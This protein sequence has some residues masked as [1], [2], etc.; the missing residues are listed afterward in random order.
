MRRSVCLLTNAYPDFPDSSRVVFIRQLAGLLSERDM[1]V[2][3]VAPR[4]F[5]GSKPRER[6]GAIEVR[7]FASFLE[8]K[9]LVQYER[10]PVF[11]L[12]GYM[13]AGALAAI[14]CVRERKCDLIHA[15]WVIPAGLIALVA[16]RICRKPVVVTAHGSD[17]L[18]VPGRSG[19]IGKLVKYVLGHADAVTSVADHL[20]GLIAEMGI[21][22]EKVLT[23][24]MSV[25][26]ESFAPEGDAQVGWEG[27]AVIFSNRSLYPLYNVETL[28][29]ATPAI[30]EKTPNAQV[31]IAGEGPER[32][33]LASLASELGVSDRVEFIGMI[34]HERMPEYLRGASVYVSTALSD[35]ASVSLLEAM[36]CGTFPVVADIPANR[37]WIDDG[38]S[39]LLFP[40][41]DPDALAERIS[42]CISQADLRNG[43]R[44]INVGLVERKAC[45]SSNVERLLEL[46]AKVLADT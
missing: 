18:V 8:N 9:L 45:W 27:K 38:S 5:A 29:R 26:T 44:E 19:L 37:E 2:S 3:V 11:R 24:P 10:T 36:A 40:P 14:R 22:R 4:I 41:E 20:T 32:E 28:V 17:L 46:Y 23:F 34:P 31:V 12:T 16:G 42:Q 1:E 13:A 39:G 25:P 15:H 21:P 33:K 35:G 7:R 30:L 6:E 43:A